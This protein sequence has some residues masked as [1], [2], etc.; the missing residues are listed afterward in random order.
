MVGT[1]NKM[2]IIYLDKYPLI[3]KYPLNAVL[4]I[5]IKYHPMCNVERI[6]SIF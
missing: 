3:D 2:R 5:Q 4:K 1:L 6:F